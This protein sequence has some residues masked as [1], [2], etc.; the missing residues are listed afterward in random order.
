MTPNGSTAPPHRSSVSLP[1]LLGRADRARC[2]VRTGIVDGVL[3]GLPELVIGGL[4]ASD[5][6]A[7][8]LEHVHGPLDAAVCDQIVAESHGNPLALLELPRAREPLF[9][10]AD[11]A[12]AAGH[13]A[14]EAVDD[15]DVRTHYPRGP[16]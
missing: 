1:R 14:E 12:V 11:A 9:A 10:Y 13:L 6:R 8:L 5:A 16:I 7:L 3:N 15:H 2:A 4:D